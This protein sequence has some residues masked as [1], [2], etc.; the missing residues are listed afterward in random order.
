ME[1]L[2]LNLITVFLQ[3]SWVVSSKDL[4]LNTTYE[5]AYLHEWVVAPGDFSFH[6]QNIS[7]LF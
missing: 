4:N 3:K 2:N 1:K 7:G 6:F 5:W